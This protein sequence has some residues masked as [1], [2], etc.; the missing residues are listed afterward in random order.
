MPISYTY[1]GTSEFFQVFIAYTQEESSKCRKGPG[2]FIRIVSHK[3]INSK[4][5]EVEN[6]TILF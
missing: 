6:I 1:E 4:F 3:D 5:L 2:L